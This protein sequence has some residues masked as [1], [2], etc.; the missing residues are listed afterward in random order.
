ME[1]NE[2]QFDRVADKVR[3]LVGGDL[4]GATVALW[5]L[6]FKAR[7]DDRRESPALHVARRLLDG[8]ATLRAHDPTVAEGPL[9]ELPGIEVVADPY[10]A[11]DGA[12]LL[13]VLTEWDEFRW[14]DF[15][16][17]ASVME[18][19]RVLDT[20]NLLERSALVRRGFDYQGLGR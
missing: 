9:D 4:T 20:R 1:V 2:D 8:G 13:V 12:D 16:K 10:A 3:A 18:A 11:C 14:L 5:G 17:V 6:T 19:P 15:D 7:T